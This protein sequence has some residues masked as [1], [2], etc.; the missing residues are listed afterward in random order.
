MSKTH[1]C[2]C[3]GHITFTGRGEGDICKICHWMED[4]RQ[5][6]DPWAEG[7][8]NPPL[9][10]AQQNSWQDSDGTFEKDPLWRPLT[11]ADKACFEQQGGAEK[12]LSGLLGPIEYWIRETSSEHPPCANFHDVLLYR[13][14]ISYLEDGDVERFEQPQFRQAMYEH[15]IKVMAYG[16]AP[17]AH[18]LMA[19]YCI[20]EEDEEQA[21]EWHR[22]A[23]WLG[24]CCSAIDYANR[25][26]M[27]DLEVLGILKAVRDNGHIASLEEDFL[28]EYECLDDAQRAQVDATAMKL[29]ASVKAQGLRFTW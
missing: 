26:G 19:I 4:L 17:Q 14:Y 18:Y 29:E 2:P 23:A 25:V 6:A 21:I 13:E 8:D 1:T 15:I 24:Y 12:I 27:E 16:R 11:P 5:L 7:P 28:D 22:K 3:C 10:E 9:F 20:C